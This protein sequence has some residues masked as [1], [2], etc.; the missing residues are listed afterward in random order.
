MCKAGAR[1][2]QQQFLGGGLVSD[3]GLVVGDGTAESC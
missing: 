3:Y 1:A 2:V